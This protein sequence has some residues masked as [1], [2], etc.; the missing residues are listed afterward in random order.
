MVNDKKTAI[1]Y[2]LNDIGQALSLQTPQ[3]LDFMHIYRVLKYVSNSPNG[4][5]LA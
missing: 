4:Y 2:E 3:I 5:S 1:E